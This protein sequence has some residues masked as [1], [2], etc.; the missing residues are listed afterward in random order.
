MQLIQTRCT[1]HLL[2]PVQNINKLQSE[3][4]SAQASHAK[5]RMRCRLAAFLHDCMNGWLRA[6]ASVIW[7][8]S[9]L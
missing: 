2:V 7:C 4:E 6:M 3:L 1:L 9:R 5:V 8:Q